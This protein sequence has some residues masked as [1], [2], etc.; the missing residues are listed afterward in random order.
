MSPEAEFKEVE[1]LAKP[2][3]TGSNLESLIIIFD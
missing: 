1:P 2:L 3:I